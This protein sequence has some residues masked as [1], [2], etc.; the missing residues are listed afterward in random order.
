MQTIGP[1]TVDIQTKE[2]ELLRQ[3]KN[4]MIGEVHYSTQVDR[5][6]HSRV[7]YDPRESGNISGLFGKAIDKITSPKADRRM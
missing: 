3:F 5:V 2:T 4:S 1:N 6:D 7:N